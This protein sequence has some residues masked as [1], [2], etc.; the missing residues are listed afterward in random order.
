VAID[1]KMKPGTVIHAARSGIVAGIKDEYKWGG[2]GRRYVGKENALVIRHSDGTFAHYLHIQN[3]GALV[4][5]GDTIQ[6]GQPIALSGHTGFSAFPHLHFVVTGRSGKNVDEIP[7][8]FHTEKGI[9]FLQPL[10]RYKA[11]AEPLS[12]KD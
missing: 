6:R 4:N 7:V 2:I 12:I 3:K 9:T 10:K 5:V 1:F 11:L 8:R